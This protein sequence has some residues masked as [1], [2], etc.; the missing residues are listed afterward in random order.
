MELTE[1]IAYEYDEQSQLSA[2][3]WY[4]YDYP[5][6]PPDSMLWRSSTRLCKTVYYRYDENG[7]KIDKKSTET[8][9]VHLVRYDQSGNPV[10]EQISHDPEKSSGDIVVYS[11]YNA[12]GNH[13]GCYYV[14]GGQKHV[15]MLVEYA[16]DSQGNFIACTIRGDG[17]NV[18]ERIIERTISYYE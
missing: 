12:F 3:R 4:S 16:Y 8:G 17:G 15:V 10:E 18:S 1:E 11:T 5:P 7:Q 13:T 6:C 2:E 9:S 14:K